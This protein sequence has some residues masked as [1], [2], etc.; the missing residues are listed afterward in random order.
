MVKSATYVYGSLR[1]L[2]CS[3]SP[4]PSSKLSVGHISYARGTQGTQGS[5]PG[6][7]TRSQQW[8]PTAAFTKSAPRPVGSPQALP[9]SSLA[10]VLTSNH[11]G[12]GCFQPGMFCQWQRCLF[13]QLASGCVPALASST[14]RGHSPA[15]GKRGELP[16]ISY[17]NRAYKRQGPRSEKETAPQREAM[18][19]EKSSI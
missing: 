2:F 16:S 12:R 4:S 3:S 18:S 17:G 19:A 15:R 1:S 6:H 7:P 5:S 14:C 13:F 9:V 8:N 11:Q 10:T